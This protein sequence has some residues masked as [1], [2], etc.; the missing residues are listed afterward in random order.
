MKKIA[1]QILVFGLLFF[2]PASLF[3]QNQND[4]A[5]YYNSF[6]SLV[7]IGNTGL[8]NGIEYESPF[9]I[10]NNKHQFFESGEYS[11]GNVIYD[12]QPYYNVLMKY[13]IWNDDVIVKLQAEFN[14][15][16]IRL[17]REK[18]DEFS[19]HGIDFT[20]TAFE[21]SNMRYGDLGFVQILYQGEHITAIK[22]HRR[23]KNEIL[24]IIVYTYF[25]EKNK[26]FI[27]YKEKEYQVNSKK[28]VLKIIPDYRK[29]I[30]SLYKKDRS[31]RKSNFDDFFIY[32]TSS[33]D[34]LLQSKT[35]S[36]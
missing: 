28:D 12:G 8:C 27:I 32:M 11:I 9:K 7:N 24:D 19:I 2:N 25:E 21:N 13:D 33:V 5:I 15:H 36:K 4:H 17:I 26:Y 1:L 16:S 10:L 31:N 3:G 22:K 35:P 20:N 14:F 29:E 34:D 23:V 30:K 6:D 18:V